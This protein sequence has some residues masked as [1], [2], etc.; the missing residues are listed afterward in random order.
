MCD[1]VE[2]PIEQ[3]YPFPVGLELP[4]AVEGIETLRGAPIPEVNGVVLRVD[5]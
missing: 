2:L 1:G 3:G 5:R 4:P